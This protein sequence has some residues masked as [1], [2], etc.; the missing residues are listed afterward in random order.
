[1][2]DPRELP[3]KRTEKATMKMKALN[4]AFIGSVLLTYYT[5]TPKVVKE[6]TLNI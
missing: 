4:T 5:Q 3:E 2:C 1:M 6:G